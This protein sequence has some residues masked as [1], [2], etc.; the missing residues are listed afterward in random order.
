MYYILVFLVIFE[1][2]VSYFLEWISRFLSNHHLI[3]K[4]QDK[5]VSP[6]IAQL[7]KELKELNKPST[8]TEYVKKS[9]KLNTLKQA[10]N[11]GTT[12]NAG[13]SLNFC[14]RLTKAI[15]NV[16]YLII[17]ILNLL[18]TKL[19]Q[20]LIFHFVKKYID[21][22]QII[23]SFNQKLYSPFFQNKEN[24]GLINSLLS[25]GVLCT[26]SDLVKHFFKH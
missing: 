20:F 23:I 4:I 8:F 13:Q 19:R 5:E 26:I 18:P 12:Q 14:T 9:R 22:S 24:T 3:R 1:L 21:K 11:D 17:R 10:L 15:I 25:Y 7:E 16:I 6:E 2:I